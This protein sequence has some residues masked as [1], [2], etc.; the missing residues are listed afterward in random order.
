LTPLQQIKNKREKVLLKCECGAVVE[1]RPADILYG[2]QYECPTCAASTRAKHFANT[3]EG[4]R[5]LKKAA[6]IRAKQNKKPARWVALRRLC[7]V[8]FDRCNNKNNASFSNYG[9]RGITV[10]FVSASEMAQWIVD[11]LGYPKKGYSLDRINNDGNYE[12][13]N[14]R[15]ATKEEQANNKRSY[16]GSVYG[17]R[18]KNILMVRP[19]ICYETART[20]IKQ[21]LSDYE[22]INREKTNAGRPRVRHT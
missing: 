12:P 19:D 9:G 14:I 2:G 18:I 11:N 21:G 20:W 17:V 8:A 22:I 1:K 4:K 3:D 5:H 16:R 15:W 6:A 10:S 7:Q 13:G